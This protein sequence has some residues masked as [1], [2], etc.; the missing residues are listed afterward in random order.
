MKTE[1]EAR[2]L[3][4]DQQQTIKKLQS[5]GATFMGDWIQIRNCYDFTPVKENSW[6]RLRTNGKTTTLTIK[7]INSTKID[8]TKECEIEVSD[9][10][11]TDELLNKLGYTA[12]TRQETRRIQ[13][14]LD[15]VEVDIDSWPKIPTYIEFEAQSEDDIKNVCKKLDI[16]FEKLVTLDVCSIYNHY[17]LK[18]EDYKILTLEDDR[19]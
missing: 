2:F 15:G 3:E 10:E 5:L 18:I 12:R 6:I 4:C 7:E 11:T 1:I 8:G 16:D 9:F 19:K 13:F 14:V 17:G